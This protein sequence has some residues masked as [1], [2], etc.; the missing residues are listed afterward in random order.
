MP[1]SFKKEKQGRQHD[2][3][4]NEIQK[5]CHFFNDGGESSSGREEGEKPVN[6]S[7]SFAIHPPVE[8]EQ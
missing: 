3:M 7:F 4:L 5:G 1:R 8:M 6:M 2:N